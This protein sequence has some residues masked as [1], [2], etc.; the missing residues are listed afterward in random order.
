MSKLKHILH[1]IANTGWFIGGIAA[2]IA[3]YSLKKFAFDIVKVNNRDM[4]GTYSFNDAVFLKKIS[5]EYKVGD[6]VYFEYPIRDTLGSQ[7]FF[8]Q[9]IF[10]LPGDS[11]SIS[12][13]VVFINRKAAIEP[14]DIKFNYFVK[15]KKLILDSSFLA[16]YGLKEGGKISDSFDYSYALTKA[17]SDTLRKDSLISYVQVK[18]EK[19]N[20]YDETCFPGD[21]HF[22]WNMD[23][24]GVVYVPRKND[25]LHLDTINIKLYSNLIIESEK[26][27]LQVKH[28][29]IFINGTLTRSYVFKKNYFFLL[30]DNRD[31][32]NDSRIWGF[33]PE[34]NLIGK[35]VHTIRKA[36]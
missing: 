17:Q 34:N 18:L 1:F 16:R 26:N 27:N 30:G 3:F 14:I 31:N 21:Q 22:K 29:S 5:N 11:I 13:K 15:S 33:L 7:T 6:V 19:K 23:Q 28:D 24:Y 8:I 35:V 32:A 2:V 4:E 20:A 25:T 36:E 12:D 9:R 10:G